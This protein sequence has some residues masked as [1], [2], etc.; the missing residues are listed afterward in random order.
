MRTSVV[1]FV[2]RHVCPKVDDFVG[3]SPLDRDL[4]R[5][6]GNQ[7]LLGLEIP[8]A[9]CGSDARDFRFNAVPSV[10]R[11]AGRCAHTA[12]PDRDP[13][14]QQV[15]TATRCTHQRGEQQ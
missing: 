11:R 2:A 9:H 7:C 3:G 12:S 6:A 5:E 10:R 1:R 8:E 14:T 15:L 4:W 13:L